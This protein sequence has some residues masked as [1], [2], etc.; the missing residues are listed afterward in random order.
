MLISPSEAI[1][2]GARSF[3]RALFLVAFLA[4]GY[5][6]WVELDRLAYQRI[7][8]V[9]LATAAKNAVSQGLTPASH[10][11]KPAASEVIGRLTIPTA[12]IDA[13][14][15]EGVDD[16]LLN[17]AIGH[18]PNTA[19]P[20]ES[21]NVALAGHRDT[22]FRGLAKLKLADPIQLVTTD[23]TYDYLVEDLR[24]VEPTE[25]GVLAPGSSPTLTLVTCYPFHYIGAAPQRYIVRAREVRRPAAVRLA[26]NV[27]LDRL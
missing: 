21:G 1:R 18:I 2:S 23:G 5:V 22:F 9:R 12:E 17:R 4:L 11:R 14:V 7:E 6:S 19:L 3:E 10:E 26:P 20:G 13:I 8:T 27:D 15:A 25:I 16:P 24:I